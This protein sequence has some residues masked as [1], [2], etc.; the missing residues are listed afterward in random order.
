MRG[1]GRGRGGEGRAKGEERGRR[2]GC[3]KGKG[4][5]LLVKAFCF[6]V[7][8]LQHVSITLNYSFKEE[9]LPYYSR[10]YVNVFSVRARDRIRVGVRARVRVGV[11]LIKL[12]FC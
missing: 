8:E 6:S 5:S 3:R 11:S 9:V 10:T 7:S 2:G 4:W 12:Q 1:E